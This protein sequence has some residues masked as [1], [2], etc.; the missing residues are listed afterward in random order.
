MADDRLKNIRENARR[1]KEEAESA[2][3]RRSAIYRPTRT[4]IDSI[5]TNLDETRRFLRWAE[6]AKP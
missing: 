3:L 6:K 1:A 4:P 5:A 2:P